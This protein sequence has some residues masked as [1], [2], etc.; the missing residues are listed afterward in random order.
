MEIGCEFVGTEALTFVPSLKVKVTF[1]LVAVFAFFNEAVR[2]P[3]ALV[4]DATTML[5]PETDAVARHFETGLHQ[6]TDRVD[7]VMTHVDE[8]AFEV[9]AEAA[10][11]ASGVDCTNVEVVEVVVENFVMFVTTWS[12]SFEGNT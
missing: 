1:T 10:T 9:F 3:A 11:V 5:F 2:V 4:P 8:L 6:V 12:S 7:A